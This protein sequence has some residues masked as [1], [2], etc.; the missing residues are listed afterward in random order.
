MSFFY[1]SGMYIS[2]VL[3]YAASCM[4]FSKSSYMFNTYLLSRHSSRCFNLNIKQFNYYAEAY[5]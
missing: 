4:A 5:T 1:I 2:S 3:T